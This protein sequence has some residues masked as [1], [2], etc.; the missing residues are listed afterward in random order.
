MEEKKRNIEGLSLSRRD[1][2]KTTASASLGTALTGSALAGTASRGSQAEAESTDEL[3]VALIGAG[4]QGRILIES[5]LRIPGIRFQAICDIWEYSQRYASRY[6]QKYGHE[7]RVYEDYREML[8]QE[9]DLTAAL[10]ATPDW[11][12]AAHAN[13]CLDAGLHVYCEKEMSNSLS[14]ARSMVQT[15]RR[16][17]KLLQ[18]GHQRRSNPRYIHAIERLLREEN[19]LGRVGQ[20]YA[21]WNRAKADMRGWPKQYTMTPEKLAQYGYSSMTAFRNWRW[22][23]KFAGG[24]I[25]DL[26]SH[27][28]DLFSWVFGVNPSSVVASGG[29]DFYPGREWYDNVMV[30]Y[31]FHNQLGTARALYQVQT[32]TKHGGFYETFMGENGSLVISEVPQRGNWAMREAHAPEWDSLVKEGL[33]QSEKPPIQKLDTRNIFLDVRVTAEAGRWPLP[34]ELAKPAHQP[35]LENFFSAIRHGTPLSCPPEVGYETAVAVL[36]VNEAVESRRLLGLRPEQ[37]KV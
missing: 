26:G 12:H 15:A 16:S 24:P 3:R 9:K 17:G 27:Q 23:K 31:E 35:H 13:A 10:V 8:A 22:Y 2:L 32:T 7:V 14:Q 30:I 25:V 28:I 34:V 36:K 6:L 20:A 1:F 19:I 11:M 5:C 21:Q 18:I 37:F 29:V 33:L 4:E